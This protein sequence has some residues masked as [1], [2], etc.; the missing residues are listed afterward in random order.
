[1]VTFS[2]GSI[3]LGSAEGAEQ[4]T[5][6]T[7][8][9]LTPPSTAAALMAEFRNNEQPTKFNTVLNIAYLLVVLDNDQNPDNGLDLSGWDALLGEET[10]DV[11]LSQYLFRG[12][13]NAMTDRFNIE[14]RRD[15]REPGYALQHLYNSLG[16]EVTVSLLTQVNAEENDDAAIDWAFHYSYDSAARISQQQIDTNAD[17]NPETQFDNVYFADTRYTRTF[18]Q[19]SKDNNSDGV[20]DNIETESFEFTENFRVLSSINEEDIGADGTIEARVTQNYTY[21]EDAI[22]YEYVL[23]DDDDGDG[24]NPGARQTRSRI[25]DENGNPIS[26]VVGDDSDNDGT[27]ESV[28]T[29]TDTYENNLWMTQVEEFDSGNDGTVDSRTTLALT[30]DTQ[31]K[32]INRVLTNDYDGDGNLEQRQTTTLSYDSEGRI[33]SEVIA[34]DSEDDGVINSVYNRSYS[35]D[36][37][38]NEIEAIESLDLD[39]DGPNPADISR[40]TQTYDDNNRVLMRVIE[41]DNNS[42]DVIEYRSTFNYTYTT[43]G[44]IASETLTSDSDGDG[45]SGTI[46]VD[47]IT[48]EYDAQGN[49]TSYLRES[50]YTNDGTVDYRFTRISTFGDNAE[51]LSDLEIIDIDGDGPNT[52]SNASYTYAYTNVTASSIEALWDSQYILTRPRLRR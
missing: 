47:A 27:L 12:G 50:D 14:E 31:G 15:L 37:N 28:T 4:I 23:I 45:D 20:F 24:A 34:T 38:G 43:E 22:S 52:A 51:L 2:I 44:L 1:M 8:A 33:L 11:N 16:I 13:L 39:G 42:D 19:T 25:F 3:V 6:F 36:S 5:P 40:I 10:V 41:E 49:M 7:L 30:Y 18:R 29:Q 17:G 35:F 9:D 46:R 21:A 48:Y 32:M 26:L